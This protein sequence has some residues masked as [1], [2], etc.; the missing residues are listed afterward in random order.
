MAN[1]SVTSALKTQAHELTKSYAIYNGSNQLE[2]IYVAPAG[3]TTGTPC[4]RV[5]YTY[6]GSGNPIKMRESNDVWNAS[7]DI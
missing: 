2:T 6:D 4:S 1:T 3:A 5:D 7:Y